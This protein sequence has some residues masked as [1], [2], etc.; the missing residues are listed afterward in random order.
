MLSPVWLEVALNGAAGRALQPGIP[1]ERNEIIEEA[2]ACV[3]AGAAI[4]HLHAY[5]DGEPL[6]DADIYGSIIEGI[7]KHCDAIVYP[8]LA[9]TG[10]LEQRLA[11]LKE[12]AQAGMLEWTVVDPGSVNISLQMQIDAGLSG[13]H[14][15]NPDDHIK[16]G[17]ELALEY[18]C[19]PAYAI[20][21]PGFVR[22]GAGFAQAFPGLKQPVYRLMFSNNLLFGCEP[23]SYALDFYAQHLNDHAN[24]APW[25]ISGLDADISGIAE[26]AIALGAHLRVG[27]ED[28]PFN[29]SQSNLQLV[30]QAVQLIDGSERSLATAME[31]RA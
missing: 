6:E 23:K 27:L 17:L 1:I 26:Q 10:D 7:K 14:Y 21:E 25:M 24:A 28:A 3:E 2:I 22:L 12:L 30:Q 13:I 19:R 16:A 8:T 20:Y 15:S 4:V 29:S 11:P 31:I 9:L 5:R 18:N